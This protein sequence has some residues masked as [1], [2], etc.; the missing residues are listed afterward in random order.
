MEDLMD[1]LEENLKVHVEQI[2]GKIGER[3]FAKHEKLEEAAN[4]I[5]HEFD[6]YGY[7]C[8]IQEYRIEKRSYKNIIVSL[9]GAEEPDKVIIVGAHYDSVLGSPGADDNASG[10]AGLLELARLIVKEEPAKTIKFIAFTNE[11]PPFFK[12]KEMGSMVYAK[13]AKER[14]ERIEAMMCLE[15]IGYFRYEEDSQTYPFPLNLFYP[16]KGDFIAVVGDI[17]SKGLVN[18][19]TSTFKGYSDFPIESIAAFGIVPGIDFSDHASFLRH[20]Y[21]GVMITD[22]AFYRNLNYHRHTDLPDTL[23]YQD[24][25]K[26]V[27]G[28]YYVILALARGSLD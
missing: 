13:N 16:D 3:N 20:G 24:L 23:N 25:T 10:I 6:K 21:R 9:I 2:A 8:E 12:T 1:T 27:K 26:V 28:F 22:T 19:I 18:K 15:M 11:E 7:K 14:R 17:A 4:Y 5:I